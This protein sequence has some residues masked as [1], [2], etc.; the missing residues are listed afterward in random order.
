MKP[1]LKQMW[2]E[3]D[4][5]LS[6]EWTIISVV[7]V[8]GIVGGLA[9]ARD[10]IIDELGDL[11]EAVVSFNQS[12]SFSGIASLGIPASSYTD[13]PST[14][15]DCGRH[16]VGSWGLAPLNDSVGGG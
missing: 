5:V 13:T 1:I 11:G 9:A 16:P 14:V 3:D 12:F 15:T 4:G 8:F 2:S 6:F 7:I 10:A